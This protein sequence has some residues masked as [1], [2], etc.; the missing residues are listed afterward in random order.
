MK[1]YL[2]MILLD[3]EYCIAPAPNHPRNVQDEGAMA[4]RFWIATPDIMFHYSEIVRAIHC[5][6]LSLGMP[7]NSLTMQ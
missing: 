7:I 6:G 3:A 1:D 2:R 4:F 5:E